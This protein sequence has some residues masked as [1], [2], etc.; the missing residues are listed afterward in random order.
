M[1]INVPL[2]LCTEYFSYY[3]VCLHTVKYL[4]QLDEIAGFTQQLI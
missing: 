3:G 4:L 1:I 2:D